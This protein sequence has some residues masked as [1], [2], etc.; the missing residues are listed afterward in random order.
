MVDLFDKLIVDVGGIIVG[1]PRRLSVGRGGPSRIML[2]FSRVYDGN[3]VIEHDK[4]DGVLV[5]SSIRCVV[6]KP[7]DIVVFHKVAQKGNVFATSLHLG[8]SI[9]QIGDAASVGPERS[10][11]QIPNGKVEEATYVVLVIA[12]TTY[13]VIV[14]FAN[15]VHP[16]GC[17]KI[18]KEGFV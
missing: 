6:G 15:N 3:S 2:L 14:D 10:D 12:N 13:R 1:G 16:S 5:E 18:W 11:D 7:I 17:F 4:G 9:I 8:D